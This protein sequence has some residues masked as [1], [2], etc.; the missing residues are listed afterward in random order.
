MDLCFVAEM[1]VAKILKFSTDSKASHQSRSLVCEIR[2]DTQEREANAQY[3]T[4]DVLLVEE[5][6]RASARRPPVHSPLSLTHV[7]S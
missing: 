4:C 2:I 5:I 6:V 1:N 7:G 3:V